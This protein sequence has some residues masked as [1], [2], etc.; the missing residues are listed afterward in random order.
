MNKILFFLFAGFVVCC[1]GCGY[2]PDE[3]SGPGKTVAAKAG[4]TFTYKNTPIDTTGK[5][6]NDSSYITVDSVAE[7]GI[8]YLGKT[9]VTHFIS[10]DMRFG[11]KSDKYVNYEDN[12][13]V[14]FST[15]GGFGAA[16]GVSFPDWNTF[17]I[18]SHTKISM[19]LVDTT[20]DLTGLG[21][22]APIHISGSDTLSYVN[23]G[24]VS[25]G[26]KSLP[27]FNMK[28]FGVFSGDMKI[29]I[30]IPVFS[31][32][33]LSTLS[34]A[35]EIGYLAKQRTEPIKNL[36]LGFPS[37]RGTESVLISYQLK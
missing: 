29:F 10:T 17:T 20:L 13:D 14:S 27:V 23:T 12:G 4:S 32:T 21:L 6:L 28:Q 26:S 37:I 36:P 16:F 31:T 19:Q 34:F 22:P 8:T 18:Q 7:T 2:N 24:T 25:V 35:P 9:H 5:E 33:A 3:P 11:I 30:V 15:G 1:I